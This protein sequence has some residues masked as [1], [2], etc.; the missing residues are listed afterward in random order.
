MWGK[1][2]EWKGMCR[3]SGCDDNVLFLDLGVG[4]TGILGL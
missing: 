2:K 1:G 4:Y 3:T